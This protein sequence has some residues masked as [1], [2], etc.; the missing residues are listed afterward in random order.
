[1]ADLSHADLKALLSDPANLALLDAAERDLIFQAGAAALLEESA[2]AEDVPG[3]LTAILAPSDPRLQNLVFRILCRKAVSHEP[4]RDALYELAIAHGHLGAHQFILEHALEPADPAWPV[5]YHFWRLISDGKEPRFNGLAAALHTTSPQVNGRL[6]ALGLAQPAFHPWATVCQALISRSYADIPGHYLRANTALRRFIRESL[7]L[8]GADDLAARE[9]AFDIMMDFG[10]ENEPSDLPD[11]WLP[12]DPFRRVVYAFLAGRSQLLEALDPDHSL[13]AQAYAQGSDVRKRRILAAGRRTGQI[14]WLRQ[15][16]DLDRVRHIDELTTVERN[17][18]VTQFL[19]SGRHADLWRLAQ[20]A[21]P[22]WAAGILNQLR[23]TGWVPGQGDEAGAYSRLIMHAES[24][25]SLPPTL[26]PERIWTSPEEGLLTLRFH[27]SGNSV[28]A[29]GRGQSVFSWE[30]PQGDLHIP[31][32][33]SPSPANRALA[34]SPDGEFIVT[35]GNDQKIRFFD[36][37]TTR[38]V[39]TISEHKGMVRALMVGRKGRS[40]LSA[41][42]DGQVL[43]Q[44]FPSGEII[45]RLESPV[46]EVFSAHLTAEDRLAVSAGSGNT[47]SVWDVQ[48]GTL[49]RVMDTHHERILF[50]EPLSEGDW[51]LAAAR[52]MSVTALSLASGLPVQEY[53][54]GRSPLAGIHA[55]GKG[56]FWISVQANGTISL[57]NLATP[58]P[59]ASFQTT[60]NLELSAYD[61][62]RSRLVTCSTSGEMALYA[63]GTWL[64]SLQS[65]RSYTPEQME[66]AENRLKSAETPASERLWLE[67]IHELNRWNQ[68]YDIEI[69]EPEPLR[70]GEFDI[71]L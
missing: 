66:Q 10:E 40:L 64:L 51:F 9:A 44:R 47:V 29:G 22:V 61:L 70:W 13:L 53:R 16:T 7:L 65:T 26:R 3:L 24:C 5:L 14:T 31:P 69:A 18:L 36:Q 21:P 28:W 35:A 25:R 20:T 63:L 2:T 50:L 49:L 43:V 55:A 1:M 27:P 68:R 32:L 54:T 33:I 41:G 11:D 23:E 71:E 8:R 19:Q 4:F 34:F 6:I 56:A 45:H 67:F 60:E 39:K 52:V 57:W 46:R 59:Q 15:L 38:L 30:L 37:R 12:A 42:F 17:D 62:L 48:S 58:T